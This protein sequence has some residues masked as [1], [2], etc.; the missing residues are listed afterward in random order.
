MVLSLAERREAMPSAADK[1]NI[2]DLNQIDTTA[3]STTSDN[4]SAHSYP[5]E[6][7]KTLI[8]SSSLPTLSGSVITPA[9]QNQPHPIQQL[10]CITSRDATHGQKHS[11]DCAFSERL[12]GA[13]NS[14]AH[15]FSTSDPKNGDFVLKQLPKCIKFLPQQ[16]PLDSTYA[17]QALIHNMSNYISQIEP[18]T[19]N[20][21][22]TKPYA[23][24]LSSILT[25]DL[26]AS[27]LEYFGS[28]AQNISTLFLK[29]REYDKAEV[30]L[31]E[32]ESYLKQLELLV[33]AINDIN[34][35][36]DLQN[37][38]AILESPWVKCILAFGKWEKE[39]PKARHRHREVLDMFVKVKVLEVFEDM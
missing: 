26:N 19:Q 5:N 16:T 21:D 10:N 4:R 39:L 9:S 23:E 31:Q 29:T 6:T 18:S 27:D 38:S 8:S 36:L 25:L 17:A 2:S 37:L 32:Y 7:S 22:K 14:A 35:S 34:T 12:E 20:L 11:Q 33:Q 30:A 3:G 1:S 13:V 15:V 24:I 28:R